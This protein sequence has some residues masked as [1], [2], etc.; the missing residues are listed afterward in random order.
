MLITLGFFFLSS[1][2]L[3]GLIRHG[4]SLTGDKIAGLFCGIFHGLLVMMVVLVLAYTIPHEGFFQRV[5]VNS[6]SGRFIDQKIM[7]IA[8]E[9]MHKDIEIP[10]SLPEDLPFNY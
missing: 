7:P 5:Y 1:F 6:Y 10:A 2:I 3:K 9:Y 4:M 8:D